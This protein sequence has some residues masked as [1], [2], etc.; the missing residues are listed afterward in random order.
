MLEGAYLVRSP[1]EVFIS[2]SLACVLRA[3]NVQ[4]D[5]KAAYPPLF[6]R[7]VQRVRHT[8]I[9]TLTHPVE[10]YFL[11][12][13]R[14]GADGQLDAVPKARE[15]P[16]TTFA[17]YRQRL[18]DA[19]ASV[20]ANAPSAEPTVTISSGYDG[21]AVAVLASELGCRK[22]VTV[23]QGKPVKDSDSLDDSG[24]PVA[25]QLG[26]ELTT[27]D[28]LA[29]QSGDDLVEADF[30]ATGFAGEEV[31]MS[32]LAS[33]LVGKML[34]SGFIGDTMWW[35]NR[36]PRPPLWRGDQSGSSLGEWRLGV[37]FVHVPLPWFGAE[38][39]PSVQAISR[40]PEMRPWVL[41]RRYDKPIPRRIL[42]EAGV[43]RG[44]FGEVKRAASASIHS[45]G[46]P[47]LAPATRRS[48]EEFAAS[49]RRV[50]RFRQPGFPRWR[51]A[52]VKLARRV[53]A[54]TLAWRLGKP[55]YQRAFMEPEFGSLLLRW[56]VSVVQRRYLEVDSNTPSRSASRPVE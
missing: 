33:A 34:V 54:E 44:T 17:E 48:V 5:P 4:L 50:L 35:L 2:N 52:G 40:S 29:Y 39:Q 56:A 25:R 46:P 38:Q 36:P 30:L 55:K 37:G 45:E 10:A 20:I 9:P 15:Q 8:T 7:S 28:R 41:G 21:A 26:L 47:A 27:A 19:L 1:E 49:E 42:E 11:D 51:R 23:R 18:S 13:L 3:A 31:A 16:F 22:A 53:G 32:G 43:Q 14:L 24:E 6:N 12:N